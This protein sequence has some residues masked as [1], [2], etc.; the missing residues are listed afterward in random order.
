MYV[1]A[2]DFTANARDFA[3]QKS[4]RLLHGAALANLIGKVERGGSGWF[5]FR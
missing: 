2:G 5:R 1:A 3:K 4:I